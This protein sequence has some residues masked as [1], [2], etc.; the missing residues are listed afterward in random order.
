MKQF[1]PKEHK[2]GW[3]RWMRW[4]QVVISAKVLGII[5]DDE[6]GSTYQVNAILRK[7][8]REGLVEYHKTGP[9]QSAPAYYRSKKRG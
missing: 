5:D 9:A 7:R 8:E 2:R 3:T 6:L 1:N 4:H